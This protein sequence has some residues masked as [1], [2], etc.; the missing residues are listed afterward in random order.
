MKN[1][2]N[3][4]SKALLDDNFPNQELID[5]FLVRKG[6]MPT[7]LD[8]SWR[9]PNLVSFV[10]SMEKSHNI[11]DNLLIFILFLEICRKND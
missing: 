6:E 4:R 10:V 3:I 9:Q 1:E 11:Y 2:L 7:A 5:E 8:L